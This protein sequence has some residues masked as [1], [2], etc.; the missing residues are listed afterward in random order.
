MMRV[1]FPGVAWCLIITMC[2]VGLIPRVEAG[3]VPSQILPS[4]PV[5]RLQDLETIR[6]V[7]EMKMVRERLKQLGF[8]PEEIQ[9]RLQQLN[10]QQ[11]HQLARHLDELKVGGGGL[12]VAILILLIVTLVLL[13]LLL[14]GRRVIVTK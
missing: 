9:A 1:L 10:D 14:T 6:Q 13:I 3:F 11:L 12:E 8:T 7:L 2:L 4:P 5:D